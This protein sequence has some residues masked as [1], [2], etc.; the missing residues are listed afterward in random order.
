M[1]R[2]STLLTALTLF[3]TPL[4]RG[5]DAAT[6]E[7]LN[8]LSGAIDNI[9]ETQ[10]D[11]SK[12]IKALAKEVESLREQAGKPTGN[13]ASAEDVKVLATKLAEVDR[14]RKED[15]ETIK[16]E[17]LNLR[18]GLL[19]DA[20]PSPG[21]KKSGS[22]PPERT[23][24][25]KPQ[26]GF[27]YDVKSGDTLGA[28]IQAYKEKGV[29]VTVRQIKDANPGLNPDVLIPGKTIFIPAPKP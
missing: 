25:D 14:K 8:K 20:G 16:T 4:A 17:L 7:R 28:I 18:K 6:E 21:K 19:K 29:K 27:N 9:I 3:G 26:E 23:A 15:A 22:P 5:Q 1:K 12:Q 24:P 10:Q 13:Y 11:L 2:I